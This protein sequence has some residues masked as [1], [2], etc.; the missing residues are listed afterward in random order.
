M[1]IGQV[2]S[3][4]SLVGGGRDNTG[5][6]KVARGAGSFPP[7]SSEEGNTQEPKQK[8]WKGGALLPLSFLNLGGILGNVS[9]CFSFGLG[10]SSIWEPFVSEELQSGAQGPR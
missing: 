2:W 7:H 6:C 8:A 10:R 1:G 5:D 3:S 4:Y 9:L